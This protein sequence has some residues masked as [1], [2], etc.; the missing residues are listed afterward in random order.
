MPRQGD[1]DHS[2]F[3]AR[4]DAM[5]LGDQ[6]ETWFASSLPVGWVWQPPR[7]DVGKDGLVVIRDGSD[8]HNLEFSIQIKASTAPHIRNGEVIVSGLSQ[9]SVQ[10]W[11]ASPLPTLV[12]AVDLSARVGWYAWHLDLFQSPDQVFGRAKTLTI[13]IPENNRLDSDGWAAVRND[14]RRHFR[15]LQRALTTDAVAPRVMLALSNIARITSNLIRIGTA[16]PPDPPLTKSERISILIEQM[17][18]RDLIATVRALLARLSD[19]SDA[20]KQLEFWL[21]SFEAMVLEGHPTLHALPPHGEPIPASHEL[22]FAPKRLVELR[23]R[24]I[25]SA[26]D[27]MRLL[28]SPHP[29]STSGAPAG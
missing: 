1:S 15:A 13:K 16:A 26:V 6:G 5:H 11:F 28:T 21:R 2:E 4:V 27:L 18:L 20:H 17:E 23:P 29:H 3:K 7:L 8:L 25:L 12:V 22:G 19:S 9:S 14:L 24:F 10:Y